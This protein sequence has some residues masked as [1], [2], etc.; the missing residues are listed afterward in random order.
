MANT[1]K[2]IEAGKM[3]ELDQEFIVLAIPD[4]TVE[5]TITAKIYIDHEL[6]EVESH[7]DFS[8][9]RAAIR[10]AQDGYIPADALFSLAPVGED[11]MKKLLEK[12][13]QTEEDE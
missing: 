12:Y 8:D 7:M 3:V 2:G 1:L 10:E 9:V 11:K 13:M 5:L 6:H 4:D